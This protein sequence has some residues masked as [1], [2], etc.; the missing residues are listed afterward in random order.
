MIGGEECR[1]LKE[2]I[3]LSSPRRGGA[4]TYRLYHVVKALEHSARQPLGRHRISALLGL[5]EASTRTLMEWLI[6]TGLALKR[7]RG[8]EPSEKG[9]KLVKAMNKLLEIQENIAS[10]IRGG[11][12][13]VV[14]TID[15]PEDLTGVYKIR[16]YLVMEGCRISVI[17][18]VKEGKPVFPG[19]EGELASTIYEAVEDLGI[20]DRALVIFIPRECLYNAYN[21][22]ARMVAE[23]V[24]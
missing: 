3:G 6:E 22:V 7:G 8:I 5:G 11:V 15:P 19:L 1:L 12:A 10:P 20:S 21:A 2:V 13:V 18:G 9:L 14:P 24:C 23:E 4:P 16:D 17:G